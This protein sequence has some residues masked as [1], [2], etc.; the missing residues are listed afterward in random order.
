MDDNSFSGCI[1]RSKEEW[2]ELGEKPT[3]YFY[4][5][6]QSRQSRHAIHELRAPLNTTE[7]TSRSILRECRAFY[8]DLYTAEPVVLPSQDWLLEQLNSALSSEEQNLCEGELSHA[9][10][11][12]AHSQMESGKSPGAD[13]FP[14]KFYS[15]FWDSLG[16]DLVD[17]L[18]F[19]FREGFSRL[20]NIRAS[21]VCSTK[22]TTHCL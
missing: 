10:C 16:A 3:R 2:T 19:S 9:E 13:G 15:R 8:K 14:A 6:E 20:R 7:K 1:L 17:T 12:A 18:N 11:H 22:K 5:L 4:Q 21:C